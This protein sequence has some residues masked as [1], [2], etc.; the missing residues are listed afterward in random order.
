MPPLQHYDC[1]FL[2]GID[3]IGLWNNDIHTLGMHATSN[4]IGRSNLPNQL[5]KSLR[6]RESQVIKM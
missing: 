5:M 6:I 2:E 4:I 1:T 3:F